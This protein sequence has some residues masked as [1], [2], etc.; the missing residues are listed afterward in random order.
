MEHVSAFLVDV[1]GLLITILLVWLL[2]HTPESYQEAYLQ[3]TKT[4]TYLDGQ[5][6]NPERTEY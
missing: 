2:I 5:E 3:N 1:T 4:N 6:R